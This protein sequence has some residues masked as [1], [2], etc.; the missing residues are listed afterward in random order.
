MDNKFN[1]KQGKRQQCH[2]VSSDFVKLRGK[3]S[4]LPLKNI[5]EINFSLS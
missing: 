3:S 5:S 4:G 2:L 1:K